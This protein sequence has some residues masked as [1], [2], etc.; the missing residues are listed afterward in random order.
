MQRTFPHI[1]QEQTRIEVREMRE[2]LD[3]W[4]PVFPKNN[5]TRFKL[6]IAILG[7]AV[8]LC[9]AIIMFDYM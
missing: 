8:L 2:R 3:A 9:E 4:E 7:F 6:T 1:D 5:P